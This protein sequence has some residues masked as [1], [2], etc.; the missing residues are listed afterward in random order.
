M[1]PWTAWQKSSPRAIVAMATK[2]LAIEELE[3][4]TTTEKSAHPTKRD[5]KASI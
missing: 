4:Q 2:L 3:L 5:E 1:A